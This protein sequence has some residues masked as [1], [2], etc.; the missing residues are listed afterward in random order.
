MKKFVAGLIVGMLIMGT[1][2]AS[3]EITA[4]FTSFNFLV[5]GETKTLESQPLV[6]NG[7]SYL[8]VREV[9]TLLGYD[10]EYQAD[11]RTIILNLAKT[12]DILNEN[13]ISKDGDHMEWLS[14]RE[15]AES[16]VE[17]TVGPEPNVLTIKNNTG[18]IKFSTSYINES[19]NSDT[20]F[21][22]PLIGSKDTISIK[23]SNGFTYLKISDL[24]AMGLMN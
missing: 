12:S 13:S 4:M 14:L 2:F 22:V 18:E 1:V 11:S 8:P 15:L 17:V 3:G 23:L 10:V 20:P 7:T 9:A 16:G 6:Y 21:E 5:D 19:K 24:K